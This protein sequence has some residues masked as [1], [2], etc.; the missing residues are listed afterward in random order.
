MP[1][2]SKAAAPG[3]GRARVLVLLLATAC[4][5]GRAGP[6]PGAERGL[7]SYQGRERE[8]KRTASGRP[9]RAAEMSCAHRTEPFG[10]LLEV[11]DEDTGRSVVVE[12][13]DRGPFVE[14][15][16]V[17]LSLAAAQAL[18]IVGRGLARVRVRRI[19]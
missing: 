15:R 9:Y 3:S 2:A 5:H 10:A 16:I 7:A 8:G 18:G 17:D 12:V 19:R 13:I 14:G 4:A 6:A 11:V 1:A